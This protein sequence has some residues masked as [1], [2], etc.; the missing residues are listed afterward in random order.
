MTVQ[1]K[2]GFLRPPRLSGTVP[3]LLEAATLVHSKASPYLGSWPLP[4]SSG[5]RWGGGE[6]GEKRGWGGGEGGK[7]RGG[8]Q[9][10]P[11][12]TLVPAAWEKAAY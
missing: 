1:E 2:C 5:S 12:P 10:L 4:A 6:K 9:L 7:G 3:I 11:A 8:A